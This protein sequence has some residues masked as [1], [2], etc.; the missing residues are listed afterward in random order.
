MNKNKNAQNQ[1]P[2][3]YQHHQSTNDSTQHQNTNN[4]TASNLS[5]STTSSEHSTNVS[6]S[7]IEETALRK[8]VK[9]INVIIARFLRIN[10]VYE[11]DQATAELQLTRILLG[12]KKL[13]M[14]NKRATFQRYKDGAY[15]YI[16]VSTF[17]VDEMRELT[18]F[19]LNRHI[20][21]ERT[22]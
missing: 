2:I 7:W 19:L 17:T 10:E 3:Q 21:N 14:D 20:L 9:D 1:G 16:V 8:Y 12:W 11:T 22:N 5:A 6:S 4:V 18:I 15:I 13:V